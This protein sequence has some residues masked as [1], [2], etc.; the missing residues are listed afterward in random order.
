MNHDNVN[1]SLSAAEQAR[2]FV[3]RIFTEVTNPVAAPKIAATPSSEAMLVPP[4][5]IAAGQPLDYMLGRSVLIMGLGDS[6]LAMA[7]WCAR[8]G[9]QVTV[10]DT[11]TEPP[12]WATL[13]AE[14]PQIPVLLG[15]PDA[16]W[17]QERG[18]H[19]LYLSP[20]VPPAQLAPLLEAAHA[21]CVNI[22]GEL[23]LYNEAL[24]ELQMRYGYCSRVLAVTGTNG[25]TTV[26]ALTGKLLECAGKSVAVAGNIGPTLLDTLRHRLDAGTLPECWV[27]ELS[28][29]QL[30]REAEFAPSAATVLNIT[31]DHL[32]WHGSSQAY[33][34]AKAHI[35][36]P[37]TFM[38][39]N[40]DDAQ[41]MNMLPASKKPCD[42]VTFGSDIPQRLGDLGLEEAADITWLVRAQD[43]NASVQESQSTSKRHKQHA[44]ASEIHLQR[45]LPVDA[46]RIYGSHNALNAQAALALAYAA[47]CSLA[48]MLYGLRTYQGEPHRV[49]SIGVVAGVEYVD[50]S[51]GTNVGATVAALTGLGRKRPLVVILGGDGKGQDFT[52]LAEPVARHARAV[53]LIGRDAG[54]I[55][56][57]LQN[58]GIPLHDCA[59]LPDAVQTA[60]RCAY[61]GD[62]VLLSPACAS[63]DMFT[64]Y[65]H[66]A[67]VFR[68]AVQTLAGNKDSGM[69]QKG[70]CE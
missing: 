44:V 40:R 54:R 43:A 8:C 6:G 48:S 29:F 16:A 15:A 65:A 21:L 18:L 14:L 69:L 23:G 47:G 50:D 52:P 37:S 38:V 66:R 67:E 51:K 59:T 42:Y 58:T 49:Q 24:R 3:A 10:A 22:Q 7:R 27:L 61:G 5:P 63:L 34:A 53:V 64:H 9:A 41:V 31:Q 1:P 45:L 70:S 36:G 26:T 20:G 35:F 56:A 60:A 33:T 25:K 46:L 32:D 13:R 28:S 55:R 68:T 4:Q 17:M 57:V 19:A 30:A 12:Q 2:K 39:L 62:V 11:R